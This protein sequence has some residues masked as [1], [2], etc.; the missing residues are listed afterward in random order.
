VP[1]F[2]AATVLARVRAPLLVPIVLVLSPHRAWA[3]ELP[4]TVELTEENS[5]LKFTIDGPTFT[6]GVPNDPVQLPRTLEWTVDGRRILV[7]PS[8]PST[9]LDVGHLHGDAHVGASQMHVQGPMLG[10]GASGTT[11]TVTGGIVYTVDGGSSGSGRS[12]ISEKVDVFNKT[13]GAISVRLTGLGFEPRQAALEVPDLSGLT[14]TGTTVTFFQGRA[15]SGFAGCPNP[16]VAPSCTACHGLP[17][18]PP[19]ASFAPVHQHQQRN[20]NCH[21]CHS[22]TVDVNNALIS[23]GAHVN[24]AVDFVAATDG[25]TGCVPPPGAARDPSCTSTGITASIADGPPFAPVT[26]L[27]VVSFS[28][29]G[30]SGFNPLFNEELS[31]PAGAALTMITELNVEPFLVSGAPSFTADGGTGG[32]SGAAGDGGTSDVASGTASSPS[33]SGCS[34]LEASGASLASL[35]V[36]IGAWRRRLCTSTR[37]RTGRGGTGRRP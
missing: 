30:S 9:L 18:P 10:Q 34:T 6:L 4:T 37:S 11:G 21:A 29:V 13:S 5:S 2:A 19:P 14:V 24:G 12:R 27:P 17:P 20:A 16:P 36:L 32:A 15:E 8:G 25:C 35:L 31:L 7:Y 22:A 1:R 3:Q 28:G 23:G 33:R 26:V